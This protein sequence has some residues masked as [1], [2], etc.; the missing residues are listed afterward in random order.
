[1]TQMKR[2]AALIQT[3]VA[4]IFALA[5]GL[6]ALPAPA[7]A[8][9]VSVTVAR[10]SVSFDT[11]AGGSV[12]AIQANDL[13]FGSGASAGGSSGRRV[14]TVNVKVGARVG[15]GDVL[16]ELDSDDADERVSAAEDSLGSARSALAQAEAAAR[17]QAE[18][19][20]RAREAAAGAR[21][22]ANQASAN[23][24]SKTEACGAA[25]AKFQVTEANEILALLASP[26]A[27]LPPNPTYAQILPYLTATKAAASALMGTCPAG[28]AMA[29]TQAGAAEAGARSA[30]GQ[31]NRSSGSSSNVGAMQSRVDSAS[32]QLRQAQKNRAA[33]VLYAPYDGVI[34][35]VNATTG[36][37]LAS[38]KPAVSIRSATVQARVDLTEADLVAVVP[39]AHAQVKVSA[40]KVDLSATVGSTDADPLPST[41]GPPSYP[42]YFPLADTSA[43]RPGQ[44]VRAQITVIAREDVIKVPTSAIGGRGTDTYV[45]VAGEGKDEIRKVAL[46]ISS[47]TETEVVGGVSEGEIVRR[48]AT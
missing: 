19:A 31:A 27:G 42:I 4:M 30:E 45:V 7:V 44:A 28:V 43:L 12:I 11:L 3:G 17:A 1:M 6:A 47:D 9:G 25:I 38:D 22:Q 21:S 48:V 32:L 10:G 14:K 5:L 24:Q 23:S 18:A 39:G 29:A 36:S 34:T 20:A 2:I 33:L 46:G 13:N 8:A 26:P 37:A 16:V 15:E 41:G 40:A 35:Q